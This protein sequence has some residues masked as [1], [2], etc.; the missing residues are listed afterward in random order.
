M[1]S[2]DGSFSSLTEMSVHR[3]MAQRSLLAERSSPRGVTST[4][5]LGHLMLHRSFTVVHAHVHMHCEYTVSSIRYGAQGL[6]QGGF[7][8]PPP[9]PPPPDLY[10]PPLK[11]CCYM[12]VHVFPLLERNPDIN[13]NDAHMHTCNIMQTFT[14]T[15][16]FSLLT[17]NYTFIHVL[18]SQ[19]ITSLSTYSSTCLEKDE[20]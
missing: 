12:Y 11:V 17:Y 2:S 13:L 18:L 6:F 14:H 8:I 7:A 3:P 1:V 15:R 9:P 10:M 16:L 5:W 20:D 19:S 4:H